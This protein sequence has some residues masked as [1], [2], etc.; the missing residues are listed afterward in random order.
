M[1]R[2]LIAALALSGSAP[3][4]AGAS[5]FTLVNGTDVPL[6]S[7]EIRR[8]P[9]G[10]WKPLPVSAPPKGRGFVPFTDED[11][12]FDIRAMVDGKPVVWSGV[13][14]CGA[15]AVSLNRN[16]TGAVWVDYD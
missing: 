12:A 7:V 14:L 2:L 8:F 5:S 6:S 9:S 11:C 13:N 3:A 16:A 1:K 4:L 10:A 15:K